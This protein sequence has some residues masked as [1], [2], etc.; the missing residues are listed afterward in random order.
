[1]TEARIL[2]IDDE[3]HIRETIQ[4]ALEAVGYRVETAA[5]GLEGLEKFGTGEE[6]DL[7]LL[8]Q[9]MP[10]MEGLEVLRCIHERDPSA[11]VMMVTAYGTI[12]L[13]VDAMKAG[14]VDFL[15]KPFTPEV[16]RGAVKAT[17]ALPRQSGSPE[18]HSLTRLLPPTLAPPPAGTQLPLIRFRTLNGFYFWP[19]SLPEG[20]E[21]TEALRIR[22]AFEVRTPSGDS[23]PCAVDITTSVRGLV[24]EETGRDYPPGD[25]IWDAIA[26]SALS[27][28]LWE[29]AELPP[30]NLPV[31]GLTREQM[32]TVRSIAGLGPSYWR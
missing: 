29:K 28:H 15:R 5:H 21:E 13:A 1:M 16:L 27:N 31:Y 4:F 8:D 26:R 12:E 17:L 10:G 22:R 25:P 9:R 3:P 7:V 32:H 11:R 30:D 20:G 18:D 14:A 19:V 6:W 23:H 2:V 24:R